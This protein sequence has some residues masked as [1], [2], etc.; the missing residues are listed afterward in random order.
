MNRI[1][2]GLAAAV[3]AASLAFAIPASAATIVIVNN[4]GPGEGFNDPTP[5]APVGGNPGVTRGQQRLFIFQHGA[6]IWGNILSSN[7]TIQV[8]AQFD[9]QTCTPTSATLG[10][11]GPVTA[12]RDFAGANFAGTWYHQALANALATSDLAALDPDINATFNVSLDSGACL[13]G[14]TWYYGIDG[15][16][17]S[18]IE[19][20]PVVLH[21]IAHGLGFSTLTS[22]STGNFFNGFPSVFDRYLLNNQ[23]GLHWYQ[24]NATQRQAS[25]INTGN[26]VWNGAKVFAEAP[27]FL[28][29]RPQLV[30]NS[31]GGIAGTT[32]NVQTATFG[33]SSFNVTGD[34]VLVDDNTG[35]VTDGCEAIVNAVAGKIALIDRGTCT[36]AAKVKNAQDAGAIAVLIA[37]NVAAGLPGMGGADPTITIPSYGISQADGNTIKANIGAPVNVTMNFHPT[38]LAGADDAGR[39]RMF[40]PNPFQGGSSVSHYDVALTPNALMEPSINSDLH[41]DVDLTTALFCDI[42]WFPLATATQLTMFT[43]EGRRDGIALRWQFLDPSDVTVVALQRS[44]AAEGPWAAVSTQIGTDGQGMVALDTETAAG[45]TYYYRLAVTDRDGDTIHMGLASGQRADA[46]AAGVFMSAPQPNPSKAGTTIRF[47]IGSPEFVRLT[48]VDANGRS[49][50]TLHEG[51]MSAGEYSRVWDGLTDHAGRV[52]PGVYFINMRTSQG[53]STQRVAIVR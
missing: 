6:N 5:A 49:I 27:G 30:T 15:N 31:P 4:D 44:R 50:R 43:A 10:S 25:A 7:V 37:N 52:S 38:L 1:F 20:L 12:H 14:L 26:L 17:G 29:G 51:M 3:L 33:P 45:Q 36:F 47:S 41:D 16:E 8:R 35:A 39:V 53:M 48:V 18:Q 13:G 34:V 42:G 40:A 32:F 19:L 11:A 9:P 21:E 24:M 23:T 2:R 28:A 46:L 22:G